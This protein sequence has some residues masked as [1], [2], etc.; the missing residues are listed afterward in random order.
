MT[1]TGRGL[2]SAAAG[3][4]RV[5][6]ASNATTPEGPTDRVEPLL[7]QRI[8]GPLSHRARPGTTS[9]LPREQMPRSR[10]AQRPVPYEGVYRIETGR[11]AYDRPPIAFRLMSACV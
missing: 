5:T 9:R 1:P 10:R 11:R 4:A 3:R 6:S 8:L 7:T 2:G